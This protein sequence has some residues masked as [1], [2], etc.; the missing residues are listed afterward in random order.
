[1]YVS[2][3]EFT[4]SG[5][6]ILEFP[7]RGNCL[8]VVAFYQTYIYVFIARLP[9]TKFISTTKTWF[10]SHNYWYDNH[11]SPFW[12]LLLVSPQVLPKL[13]FFYSLR[14]LKIVCPKL[15][16]RPYMGKPCIRMLKPQIF[17]LFFGGVCV[18]VSFYSHHYNGKTCNLCHHSTEQLQFQPL[19]KGRWPMTLRSRSIYGLE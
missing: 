13:N 6:V 5:F 15:D 17:T 12:S 2:E 1:M 7:V 4:N 10:T 11:K 18:C 9:Y 8:Y 3:D 19:L 16:A 14:W